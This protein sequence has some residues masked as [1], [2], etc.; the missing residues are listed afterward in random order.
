MLTCRMRVCACNLA[1][2]AATVLGGAGNA[3]AQQASVANCHAIPNDA[4]RL[5]CYDAA[6]A[7]PTTAP[8]EAA[9]L[10]PVPADPLTAP[11]PTAR[12]T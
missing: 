7:R 12:P 8:R 11:A 1:V 10:T 4:Q 5:D 3:F 6:T 9:P 2:S